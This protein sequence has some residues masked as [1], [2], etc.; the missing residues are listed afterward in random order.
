MIA[1]SDALGPREREVSH[2][3]GRLGVFAETG[4]QKAVRSAV[5][6]GVFESQFVAERIFLRETERIPDADVVI[7]SRRQSRTIDIGD[8][9]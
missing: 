5:F 1:P 4:M 7:R 3:L 9:R 8:I 6:I 2:H